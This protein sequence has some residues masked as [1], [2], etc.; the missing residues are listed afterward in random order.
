MAFEMASTNLVLELS[1]IMLVFLGWRCTVSEFIGAPPM[2]AF[3]VLLFRRFLSREM[4]DEAG[5]QL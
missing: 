2:V 5:R 3:L 1:I 4:L